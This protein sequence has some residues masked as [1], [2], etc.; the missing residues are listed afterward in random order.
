MSGAAA[1]RNAFNASY[2][3]SRAFQTELN[4]GARNSF[5]RPRPGEFP[6]F[7]RRDYSLLPD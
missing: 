3:N 7:N 2:I 5:G 6:F 1:D 4:C